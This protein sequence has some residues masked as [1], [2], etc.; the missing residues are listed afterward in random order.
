MSGKASRRKGRSAPSTW[1]CAQRADRGNPV[2]AYEFGAEIPGWD[3]PGAFHSVD[4][5]F[6]FETLAKCWRPFTGRHYDLAMHMCD[7]LSNFI[8]S[9]DPN[10]TG[11]TGTPLPYWPALDSTHPVLMQ[12]ADIAKPVESPMKPVARLLMDAY[13]NAMGFSKK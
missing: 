4:L 9:G 11:T 6:F 10:G 1:R 3:H 12:F 2:Y 5:W 7:Y 13:L 8:R